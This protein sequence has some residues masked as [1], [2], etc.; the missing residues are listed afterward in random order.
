MRLNHRGTIAVTVLLGCVTLTTLYG[1]DNSDKV[2]I[3][4]LITGRTGETLKVRTGDGN[5]TDG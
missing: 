5:I 3:R 1:L 4:K 2:K